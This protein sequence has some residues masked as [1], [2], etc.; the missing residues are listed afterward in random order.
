LGVKFPDKTL[1]LTAT[2]TASTN[3]ADGVTCKITDGSIGC[4]PQNLGLTY[5]DFHSFEYLKPVSSAPN[6][7]GFSLASDGTIK[8]DAK[9]GGNVEFSLMGAN[10]RSLYA[11][12]CTAYRHPD[13]AMFLNGKAFADFE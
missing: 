7:K 1:Y 10:T 13:G 4:G 8:W 5:G 2:T 11:Q 3:K 9:M 12:I 6:N